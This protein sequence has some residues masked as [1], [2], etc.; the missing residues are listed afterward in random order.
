MEPDRFDD[1]DFRLLEEH[2]PPRREPRRRRRLVV[3]AAAAVMGAGGLAAGAS[4]LTGS[5]E[6]GQRTVPVGAPKKGVSYNADGVP[7]V[8][9]GPE[10]RGG[11]G[12][13]GDKRRDGRR[14]SAP[15]Y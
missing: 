7:M 6:Q 5:G 3:V 11:K 14:S 9:S 15:R 12:R 10:C 4:A 13:D 1:V 8:R 2:E